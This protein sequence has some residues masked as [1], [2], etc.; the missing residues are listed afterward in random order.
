[1]LVFTVLGSCVSVCLWDKRSKVAAMNHYLLP[2]SSEDHT[3]DANRGYLSINLMVRSLKNRKVN[4][5]DVEAKVFGG[6]NSLYKEKDIYKIGE[7]NVAMALELLK[8]Y[9]ISVVAHHVGGEFGRKIVFN[10]AT[11]KVRMRLLK[12]S[13]I[14]VNEEIDKGFSY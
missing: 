9:G 4:L 3:G 13:T 11:G 12:K 1:M 14:E 7:R 5:R 8:Q 10:T 2:G 6:S